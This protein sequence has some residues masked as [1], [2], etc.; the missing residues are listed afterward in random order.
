[1]SRLEHHVHS[2]RIISKHTLLDAI[3][4]GKGSQ[5]YSP[6]TLCPYTDLVMDN[7]YPWSTTQPT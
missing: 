1:M 6:H 7:V 5:S 3:T 4:P 2:I